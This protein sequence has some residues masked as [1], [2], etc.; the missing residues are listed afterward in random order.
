MIQLL[1]TGDLHLGRHPTRIP[2]RLDGPD[3]SPRSVW[4]D[5]VREAIDRNVDGVLL[6]GDVADRENRYFEAFGAFEAGVIDL[7]EAAI[8]TVA[9][10]GN[11]DATFLPRMVEDID[12]ENLH[13]LGDQ[14]QWERHTLEPADGATVHLEGWSF[15]SNRVSTS[16]LTEYDLD[17][18]DRDGAR[19]GLLHAELNTPESPYAPVAESELANTPVEWWLL[20]HIHQPGVRIDRDPMVFYPGSP[21]PLDPGE[22]GI[23]GPWLLTVGSDGT[24]EVEQVPIG[25]AWYDEVTVDVSDE[26]DL[27]AAGAAISETLQEHVDDRGDET[28]PV[29][30]FL[31]RVRLTG[32]SPAHAELVDGQQTL[33]EQLATRQ[34]SIDVAIESIDVDT[35]PAVDLDDLAS[36]DGPVAYLADLLRTLE[37]EDEEL[38]AEQSRLVDEAQEKMQNVQAE[39]AYNPLRRETDLESPGREEAEETL[40]RQARLLLDTLVAQ[41]EELA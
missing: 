24:V 35:R 36:D 8:P 9:V 22:T 7:E 26:P 15:P 19:I 17:A 21:Q 6:S 1:A 41:K 30:A 10:A 5:I 31:A 18:P 12:A 27:Q 2:D 16:P 14:G 40:E 3:F 39:N 25:T 23:R 32:R 38:E 13:L 29:E 11:H 28:G 34:G 4:R 20:G 37:A 33:T